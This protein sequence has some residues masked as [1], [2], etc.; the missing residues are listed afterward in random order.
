[1]WSTERPGVIE[2]G[3][4]VPPRRRPC[5]RRQRGAVLLEAVLVISVL[6]LS[7]IGTI[8]T[9]RIYQTT[10]RAVAVSRAAAIGYSTTACRGDDAGAWFSA[11]E[12]SLLTSAQSDESSSSSSAPAVSN[13]AARRAL[14]QAAQSGSFGSPR[15]MSTTTK[16][17]V[18][19]PL[20]DPRQPG[21]IFYTNVE[22]N[23]HVLCGELSH[24]RGVLGALG[25]ARDFFKF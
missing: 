5:R 19:G 21:G 15:V 12:A 20:S 13:E 7:L 16:G 2:A 17:Q 10:L 23:D 24:R 14:S 18:F 6:L 4:C 22:A 3:V 9:A 8:Y 1:M 11:Q 25:F